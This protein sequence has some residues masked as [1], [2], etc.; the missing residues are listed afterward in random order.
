MLAEEPALA[1]IL[2]LAGTTAKSVQ[3]AASHIRGGKQVN[4]SRAEEGFEALSKCRSLSP[5]HS[6]S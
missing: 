4:S 5:V 3:Q 6:R 2:K 1:A